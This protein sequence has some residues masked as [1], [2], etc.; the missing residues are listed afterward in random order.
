M[1][2]KDENRRQG[3]KRR[4]REAPHG[5]ASIHVRPFGCLIPALI[6]VI[7]LVYFLSGWGQTP[8]SIDTYVPTRTLIFYNC[9]NKSLVL[10]FS[11]DTLKVSGDLP[12]DEAAASFLTYIRVGILCKLD[13][14][15]TLKKER[16]QIL[17]I[18]QRKKDKNLN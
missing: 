15:E 18:L 7:L 6:L 11:S 9:S 12:Y 5:Q 17:E 2:K 3:N 14:L 8:D 13:T 1:S 10:D 16:K 4:K